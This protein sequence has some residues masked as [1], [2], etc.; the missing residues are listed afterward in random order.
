MKYLKIFEDFRLNEDNWHGDGSELEDFSEIEL[1]LLKSKGFRVMQKG[2]AALELVKQSTTQPVYF[3]TKYDVKSPIGKNR[4][5]LGK[6]GKFQTSAINVEGSYKAI[7]TDDIDFAIGDILK[8]S[9]TI[10][11]N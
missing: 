2:K 9:S 1:M 5:I 4:T 7:D 11:N 6:G 8:H 3:I 10:K